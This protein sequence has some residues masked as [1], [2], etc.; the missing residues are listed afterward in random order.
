MD[1]YWPKWTSEQNRDVSLEN[2]LNLNINV[3]YSKFQETCCIY[4]NKTPIMTLRM[5][6]IMGKEGVKNLIVF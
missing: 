3:N 6:K 5:G 4:T 2:M 1:T